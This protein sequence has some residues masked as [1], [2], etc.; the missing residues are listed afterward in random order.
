MA[1]HMA[2]LVGGISRS[3]L[4]FFAS[5]CEAGAVA[6]ISQPARLAFNVSENEAFRRVKT[7]RVRGR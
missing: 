2:L 7:I 6:D 4:S 5:T 1:K 3:W